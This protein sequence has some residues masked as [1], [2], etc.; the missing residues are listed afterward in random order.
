MYKKA[1]IATAAKLLGISAEKAEALLKRSLNISKDIDLPKIV[2]R[3]IRAAGRG[4]E[5]S[6]LIEA[7]TSGAAQV[8][9]KSRQLRARIMRGVLR[10]MKQR[11]INPESYSQKELNDLVDALVGKTKKHV[12]AYEL[13]RLA[14]A[15]AGKQ[16][17]L[18]G[19][20]AALE[21]MRSR[22]LGGMRETAQNAEKTT[23]TTV[24]KQRP[25]IKTDQADWSKW[26]KR[27]LLGG[28]VGTGLFGLHHLLKKPPQNQ[29]QYQYPQQIQKYASLGKFEAALRAIKRIG[30]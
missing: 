3:G 2:S 18:A 25:R 10:Q 24:T 29:Y 11:G 20:R 15:V 23:E 13:N 4:P 5:Q 28:L 19:Q 7:G 17:A 14:G 9:E 30:N 8:A 21:E 16:E 6:A 26:K 27:L 1:D 12:G 22:L